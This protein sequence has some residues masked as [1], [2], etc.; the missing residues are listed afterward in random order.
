[1]K[2]QERRKQ[3]ARF[4]IENSNAVSGS[5]LAE[6]FNVSRQIIVHDIALLK[7]EGYG[8]VST[9]YGYV[10][11]KTP[12]A[13]RVLKLKHTTE[14]TADELGTIVALGGVVEDVF[15]WHKVYGKIQARL[16]IS[17]SYHVDRFIDGVRSGKSTELMN[18][19][20]GYHYHTVTAES[21]SVLDAIESALK[22]K[23]FIASGD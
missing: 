17:S 18:I 12:F 6:K 7:A 16:N 19:T 8:V 23:G 3:I 9:H 5:E 10:I 14:Q 20:G 15:V 11:N 21:E 13:K 2:G 4:L 1:M 22:Q